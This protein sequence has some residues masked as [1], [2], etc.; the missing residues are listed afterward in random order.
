MLDWWINEYRYMY[1]VYDMEFISG[2]TS[3]VLERPIEYIN[4]IDGI[5]GFEINNEPAANWAAFD[6]TTINAPI[7]SEYKYAGSDKVHLAE[8][9]GVYTY[10]G[11]LSKKSSYGVYYHAN[12][13]K[14]T[15][16][17]DYKAF[18]KNNGEFWSARF[19]NRFNEGKAW[20]IPLMCVGVIALIVAITSG[21]F[22]IRDIKKR[23]KSN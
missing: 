10:T 18:F 14:G 23:R 6:K 16:I 13:F 11:N 5:R 7:S 1:A 2:Q 12:S 9:N 17:E 21:V 15:W 4:Y 22:A 20:M 19:R 3:L 8:S